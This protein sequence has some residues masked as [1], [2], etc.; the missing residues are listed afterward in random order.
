MQIETQVKT[1]IKLKR[2]GALRLT[3]AAVLLLALLYLC[4]LVLMPKYNAY[5]REGA[6]VSEY[7]KQSGRNNDVIF[8]GDCEVYANFSPIA[9]YE[10]YGI[11]SY[12]QGS[13]QQLVWQSYYL[14][15]E[16]LKYEKPEVVVFNTFAMRYSEP[17]NEA[18]NRMTLD[19]LRLSSTKIKAVQASMTEDESLFTYL[20]PFFRFHSRWSEL[21]ADDF[22]YMFGLDQMSHNGYLMRVDIKPATQ[23]PAPPT[24]TDYSF[25]DVC[26]NY[27]DKMRALCEKN[28]ITLILIKSPS[29]YP[30]WYEQWDQQMA[31]YADKHG[32]VYINFLNLIDECGIDMSTDTYDSGLHLNL[33]GAEKLSLYFGKILSEQFGMRDHRQDADIHAEWT[34]KAQRYYQE[35]SAQQAELAHFGYLKSLTASDKE[36]S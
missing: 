26:Y 11:T 2:K 23:T 17:Q 15:E 5:M 8:L 6:L 32:L 27:L 20:F 28:G 34:R 19:G 25:S 7:Y 16:T 35:K 18:F 31:D 24:L 33:S 30:H 29:I 3:A 13:P 9:L 1:D 21:K 12:I 4:Q 10:N 14:L 22:R 36:E